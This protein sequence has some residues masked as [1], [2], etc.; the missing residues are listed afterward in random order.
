MER[1]YKLCGIGKAIGIHLKT[2]AIAKLQS[3]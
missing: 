3:I 2:S 1:T